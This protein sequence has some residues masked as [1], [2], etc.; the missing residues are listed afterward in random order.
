MPVIQII[1]D[2]EDLLQILKFYFSSEGFTVVDDYNGDRF[3]AGEATNADIYLVDI[4]LINKSGLDITKQIKTGSFQ[5]PVIL[6][7]ANFHL[8]KLAAESAADDFIEKP[9]ELNDM[10]TRVKSMIA[11]HPGLQ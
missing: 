9:F 11:A 3:T 5:K 2:D 4:N 8:K 7:S 10:I 1:E 6:M